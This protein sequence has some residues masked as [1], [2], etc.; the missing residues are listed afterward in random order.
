MLEQR[1]LQLLSNEYPTVAAVSSEIINLRAIMNLP[2]GT[3]YFFSDLH[4]EHEAFIY[5]LKSASGVIATTI[6]ELFEKSISNEERV[7]LAN[8]IYYPE[9]ELP[10]RKAA[11]AQEFDEWCKLT[12]YRL[13]EVCR[14]VSSKYTRSKVRKKLPAD[15]AYIMDELL[16]VEEGDKSHYFSQI[17]L[18]IVETGVAEEFITELCNLIRQLTVDMLH[19]VGD[20]YDR[21]PRADAIL[22]ELMTYHDVDIQWGNHDIYWM[23]AAMGNWACIANAIRLGIS[24]NNF[25]LLEDGYGINLR[26]LSIFAAKTYQEDPC[27]IFTPHILDENTYDPVDIHLAAK[28]HKAIAVIQFKLEAQLIARHPEYNMDDRAL[29]T[30]VNFEQGTVQVEGKE[31]PMRDTSFPTVDPAAPWVLSPEEEELMQT[32]S[33]SFLHSEPLQ[34]HLKF[35]FLKGSIY[36]A[37]N[38]NLLYH[39]CVPLTEEGEFDRVPFGEKEYWGKSYFDFLNKMVHDAYFAPRKAMVDNKGADFMW[40]LWAGPKSPLFGKSKLSTFERYFVED[41]ETHKEFM[42]PYYSLFDQKAICEKILE[43][44]GLDPETS[45]IINGHVPVKIKQGEQPIKGGGKLFMI[46]GGISKAYQS[47]TGIGG[48]T[49]IYNSR[50]LALAE[51]HPFRVD[52]YGNRQG[53]PSTVQIVATMPRRVRVADTDN[54]KNLALRVQELQ[55]LL[56]AYREGRIAERIH[57]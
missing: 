18:S 33:A 46:D 14:T 48:Y 56:Q 50:S 28:M 16:H 35:L 4:G 42:N 8:L 7:L 51:H 24:Y 34:R 38:G 45:H 47:K 21:G 30:Q 9:R 55:E 22:D 37:I 17:I 29:L 11:G 43:E 25:D 26:A 54:G 15:F 32:I 20:V 57:R 3:E 12:I 36:K 13:V 40:Y 6:D 44:F 31:Y 10:R 27:T 1:Y 5:L 23:G 19:I 39:G 53:A 52:A 2:K 49:L 41:K